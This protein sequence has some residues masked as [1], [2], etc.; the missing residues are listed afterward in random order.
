[1]NWL[2]K[3]FKPC[4]HKWET[5]EQF[6]VNRSLDGKQVG[7]IYVLRCAHCGDISRRRV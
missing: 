5:I 3:L 4:A 1:M 2:R 6:S 7:T